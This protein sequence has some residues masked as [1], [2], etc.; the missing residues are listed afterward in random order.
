MPKI[1]SYTEKFKEK[2]INDKVWQIIV[3]YFEDGVKEFDVVSF[4]K[5]DA[6]EM[7]KEP[8]SRKKRVDTFNNE[9]EAV[10][11]LERLSN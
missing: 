6:E 11:F 9:K 8:I 4:N 7:A 3:I 10:E 5:S 1:I 2:I